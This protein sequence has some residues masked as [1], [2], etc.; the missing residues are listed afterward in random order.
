MRLPRVSGFVAA[1][2]VFFH[3]PAAH[4]RPAWWRAASLVGVALVSLTPFVISGALAPPRALSWSDKHRNGSLEIAFNRAFWGQSRSCRP[5][6]DRASP[7]T[8]PRA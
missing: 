2:L 1:D 5:P 6:P 8:H 7:G 4:P 3:D